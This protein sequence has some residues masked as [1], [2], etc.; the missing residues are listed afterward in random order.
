MRSPSSDKA[1]AV[2]NIQ[3]QQIDRLQQIQQ[4]QQQLLLQLQA[5]GNT[6]AQRPQQQLQQPQLQ[7]QQIPQLQ[8]HIHPLKNIHLQPQRRLQQPIYSPRKS[9]KSDIERESEI[10]YFSS[11]FNKLIQNG[12]QIN[13]RNDLGQ[14]FLIRSVIDK[15]YTVTKA[16]LR[17]GELVDVNAVDHMNNNALHYAASKGD[18][19]II[20][21]FA[22]R[23][24][25][26]L[27]ALAGNH[28][29]TTLQIAAKNGFD[30]AVQALIDANASVDICNS[31]KH[32]AL[33][34]A[35]FFWQRK[36]R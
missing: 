34:V 2:I 14:T 12:E 28:N 19:E 31:D 8:Y 36:C 27:N 24:D 6:Y 23:K 33:H 32:T 4:I 30:K 1:H 18:K 3:L 25:V 20:K 10:I 29:A 22:E 7:L 35:V 26:D 5:P 13:Y 16:L 11:E 9:E 15:H 17:L 21:A